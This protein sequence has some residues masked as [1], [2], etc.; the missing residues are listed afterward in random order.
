MG[1]PTSRRFCETWVRQAGDTLQ[2]RVATKSDSEAITALIN[3]AFRKAEAFFIDGDRITLQDVQSLM[4]KGKFLLAHDHGTVGCVYV[5]LRGERAYLGLL[6]VDPQCQK[7]GLGSILMTS[8]E[9]YCSESGCRFI[10][11]QIVNLRQ[12]L[13]GFYRKRGYTETGTAPFPPDFSP[14]LPCHFV[15]WSKALA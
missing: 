12:E 10:D 15:K 9:K 4:E 3:T 2:V 5:E 1:C 13:P 14:K 7:A 6:A 8:A 11:L